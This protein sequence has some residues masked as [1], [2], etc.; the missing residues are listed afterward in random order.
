M[1]TNYDR[2]TKTMELLRDGL[3]PFVAREMKASSGNDWIKKA[4]E[5]HRFSE[6]VVRTFKDDEMGDVKIIL[7]L[8]WNFWQEVFRKTLGH[9]ERSLVSELREARNRWAHQETFSTDDA[10]RIM[11]SVERLLNAISAPEARQISSEKERLMRERFEQ[12][13]RNERKKNRQLSIKGEPATSLKPWR[14]VITPHRDVASGNYRQAEFAANLGQVH[15]RE[16]APEYNEPR[17]FFRR[18]YLTEGLSLL[19]QNALKRL[20][21]SAGNPVID[22]QT[23]FGGGK[24]HSMIALWHLFSG[25]NPT[26]MRGVEELVQKE[27]IADLP[28]VK[29]AVLMGTDLSPAQ[30]QTKEDGLEVRTLWGELA[31]QLLGKKGFD[32]VA[33]AD[34]SGIS[35]GSDVLRSLF[36]KAGPCLILI[37]EWVAFVRQLYNKSEALSG[38]SFEAN[39]SFAQS[40]TESAEAIPNTLLVVSLP[41][42]KNEIGGEGGEA[43]MDR[44]KKTVARMD[45]P[46][47]PASA[48]ESF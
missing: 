7:E 8:M 15:R 21:T 38:G 3:K 48:E 20:C 36:R 42:S 17:E 37:D 46:W 1:A 27:G 34:K 16:A 11:D 6:D 32:M 39:M 29:R 26:F 10:Y 33:K 30:P 47:R 23:N 43:A 2:V 12:Q 40:L 19:L 5:R 9:A 24:T 22:L 45:S 4:A 13:T 28:A 14:E 18:T 44:L 35:P 25:E 41:A 31:W